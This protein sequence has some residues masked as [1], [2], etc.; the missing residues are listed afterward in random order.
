MAGQR[1]CPARGTAGGVLWLAAD[2]RRACAARLPTTGRADNASTTTA[3]AVASTA[4]PRSRAGKH[5]ASDYFFFRR[6]QSTTTSASRSVLRQLRRTA[7]SR[8][9]RVAFSFS[10][11][12]FGREAAT[13]ASARRSACC[14]RHRARLSG[15]PFPQRLWQSEHF[16]SLK[17]ALPRSTAFAS[18][19]SAGRR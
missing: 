16:C 3:A 6:L 15:C 9:W 19:P 7:A 2:R 4:H 14:R 13:G 8:G 11:I 12:S 5:R 18:C 10:A 1:R 17:T